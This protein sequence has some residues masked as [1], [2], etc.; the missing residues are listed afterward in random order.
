[1]W[2]IGLIAFEIFTGMITQITR[3]LARPRVPRNIDSRRR[4]CEEVRRR[5]TRSTARAAQERDRVG[6]QHLSAADRVD[7]AASS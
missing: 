7:A 5:G 2:A 4:L 6:D 3:S 1:M